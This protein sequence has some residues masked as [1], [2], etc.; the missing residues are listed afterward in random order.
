[1][2]TFAE[3]RTFLR[4]AVA[5]PDL[6]GAFAPTST[7]MAAEIARVVPRGRAATVVELGAGTG[8][9]CPAVR[10]R[11][12]AGSRYVAIEVDGALVGHLRRTLPWL[13]VL[14]GDAAD[15]GSLL[16]GAAV[17]PVDA[18]VSSLPWTFLPAPQRRRMLRS[19]AASL[20]PGGVFAT[21]TVLAAL[22]HRVRALH[23]DL[24]AV[25]DEVLTTAPV[26]RNL[27]P[28]RLHVCRRPC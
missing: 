2:T 24:D 26:W 15:L 16:A 3:H 10:S 21:I 14:H 7:G 11:L 22:P 23:A 20:A 9:L 27:P 4:R 25:F 5:R 13:D 19:V 8:A 17:G 12:G 18:V 28:A 6:M 1:M